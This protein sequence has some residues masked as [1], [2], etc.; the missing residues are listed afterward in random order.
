MRE[1]KK[2]YHMKCAWEMEK[3]IFCLFWEG[4]NKCVCMAKHTQTYTYTSIGRKLELE[5]M[6]IIDK[7][8]ALLMC[9]FSFV[10]F[11]LYF[12]CV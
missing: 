7:N 12:V 10:F 9:G 4:D 3:R 1:N 2:L 11:M 8:A 5:L 6:M